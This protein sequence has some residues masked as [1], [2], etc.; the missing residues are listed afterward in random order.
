MQYVREVKF[1]RKFGLNGT[2][3]SR[4][5]SDIIGSRIFFVV[6][7]IN[8]LNVKRY[9]RNLRLCVVIL[10]F[11]S[12]RGWYPRRCLFCVIGFR[13]IVVWQRFLVRSYGFAVLANGLVVGTTLRHR[14]C[15]SIVVGRVDM[16]GEKE[17]IPRLIHERVSGC[18]AI[19]VSHA[20]ES[21]DETRAAGYIVSEQTLSR[22]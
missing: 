7:I 18:P 13:A 4:E 5:I 11:K 15:Q 10:S 3:K 16:I 8:A 21:L 20:T 1:F 14:D 2:L 17:H 22:A 19:D 12:C 6:C 9:G